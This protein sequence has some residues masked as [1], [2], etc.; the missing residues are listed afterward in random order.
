MIPFE[1]IAIIGSG[2]VAYTYSKVLKDN[3]INLKY[4][5][6]LLSHYSPKP[7]KSCLY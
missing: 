5:L 7:I 3:G 1:N 4:V 6:I 2:N